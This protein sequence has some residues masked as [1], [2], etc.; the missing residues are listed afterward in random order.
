MK[1]IVLL[2]DSHHTI[3]QR[4]F[5]HLKN[6]DEIYIEDNG[7]NEDKNI[8]IFLKENNFVEKEKMLINKK[9]ETGIFNR[10]FVKSK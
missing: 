3:D 9:F 6:C 10:I 7:L 5:P 2:S 4:I 8:I 1:R